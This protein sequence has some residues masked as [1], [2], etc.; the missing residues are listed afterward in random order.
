MYIKSIKICAYVCYIAIA[1]K[2]IYF[3]VSISMKRKILIRIAKKKDKIFKIFS[4]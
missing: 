2:I 3:P 1:H 4:T